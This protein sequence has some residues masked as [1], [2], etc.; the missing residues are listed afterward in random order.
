MA[1]AEATVERIARQLAQVAEQ[2][3]GLV[4]DRAE[5]TET[6]RGGRV[7]RVLH[8]YARRPGDRVWRDLQIYVSE[9]APHRL[10]RLVFIAEVTE[11]V[12]L[13]NGA[14]ANA[15]TLGHVLLTHIEDGVDGE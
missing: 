2:F 1:A 9:E 3:P 8:V 10:T 11:P 4:F 13:P 7:S 12:A 5:L 14:I 15:E 6:L